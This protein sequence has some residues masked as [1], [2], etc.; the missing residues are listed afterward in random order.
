[1]P[2]SKNMA[3]IRV[4]ILLPY[5]LILYILQSMVFTHLPLLGVK[6]M[7]LPVAVA[8]A[9]LFKGPVSGGVFGIFAGMLCDLSYNQPTIQFTIMLTLL[10]IAIGLLADTALVRGFPSFLLC[11]AIML[12]ACSL[13]QALPLTFF[14]G[15]KL[16][17]LLDTGLRQTLYSL[18]FT[19]PLYYVSR[20]LSRIL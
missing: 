18:V 20:F 1:M 3:V 14:R 19:I 9:S 13:L 11:S 5:L 4:L 15:L 17:P 10:G 8:G 7:I 16:A 2:K 6:P 12:L